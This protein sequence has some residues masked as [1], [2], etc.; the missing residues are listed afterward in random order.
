MV[1]HAYKNS[2][3]CLGIERERLVTLGW[4]REG[5]DTGNEH[6]ATRPGTS[7]A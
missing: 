5:A 7:F 2:Q 6:A 4:T 1:G 3:D